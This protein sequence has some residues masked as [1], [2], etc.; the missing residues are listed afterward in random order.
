MAR[1]RGS[2][3]WAA[4]VAQGLLGSAVT[5][6]AGDPAPYSDE[7]WAL[8]AQEPP[9]ARQVEKDGKLWPP[10]PRPVGDKQHWVHQYHH[11]HYWPY[12]Y[13]CDDEAYVRNIWQQQA[14]N[15]WMSATTLRD[16]HFDGE[17]QQLNSN[18]RQHLYWILSTAPPQFRTIYVAQGLSVEEAAL[19][20]ASVERASRELFADAQVPVLVR[21]EMYRGRPAQEID[22]LRRLELQS[23]PRPRLFVI[24]ARTTG[25]GG[26]AAGGQQAGGTGGQPQ[27]GGTP[28]R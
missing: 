20:Q 23:M 7:S 9:G 2:R 10:F 11:S 17:T 28:T 19:R 8:R 25:G 1:S 5:A 18:G 24:G 15:G 13:N 26:A 4:L 22:Q 21:H 12:P 27:S 6:L 16:Y 3:A 14:S